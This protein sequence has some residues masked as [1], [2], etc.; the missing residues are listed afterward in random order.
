MCQ[1]QERLHRAGEEET[2]EDDRVGVEHDE[3]G[4]VYNLCILNLRSS[5]TFSG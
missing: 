2:N 4:A 1:N 5:V 3:G